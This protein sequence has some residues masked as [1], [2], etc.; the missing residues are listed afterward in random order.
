M[1]HEAWGRS[2]IVPIFLRAIVAS[3]SRHTQDAQGGYVELKLLALEQLWTVAI[4]LRMILVS[5]RVDAQESSIEH[6]L[7]HWGR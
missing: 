1:Q 7:K 3:P 4:L 5:P 2:L 6:H